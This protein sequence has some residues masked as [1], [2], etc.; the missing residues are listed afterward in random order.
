MH[1]AAQLGKASSWYHL[2]RWCNDAPAS[3]LHSYGRALRCWR[4]SVRQ[5]EGKG[6]AENSLGYAYENGLGVEKD[7]RKALAW[8]MLGGKRGS[9]VA[10]CNAANYYWYQS[11]Y[12]LSFKWYQ[13]SKSGSARHQLALM[14]R[15]GYGCEKNDTKV[16]P[17]LDI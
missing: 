11:R 1:R 15:S 10:A 4:I 2:G 7:R 12:H 5:R 16:P 17:H 14:Y 8:Y 9:A 3:V 13:H 6:D